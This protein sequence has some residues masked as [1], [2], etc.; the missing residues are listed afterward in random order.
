M[1]LL[2]FSVQKFSVKKDRRTPPPQHT[3]G[4]EGGR[5]RGGVKSRWASGCLCH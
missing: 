3:M 5:G 4:E 1:E 2:G